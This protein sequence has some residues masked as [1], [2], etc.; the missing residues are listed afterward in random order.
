M[1]ITAGLYKG[2]TLCC[3][4]QDIRPVM[5]KMRES[6][7]SM[8]YSRYA[9][10]SRGL[11]G[12]RFLDLFCGSAVMAVEA[13]SRGACYVEAVERDR[14]K[15]TILEQNLGILEIPWRLHITDVQRYLRQAARP[16]RNIRAEPF[17]II[18]LDPPFAM[19]NKAGLLKELPSTLLHTGSLIMLH[20]PRQEA[21]LLSEQPV[22]GLQR[23]SCKYFG[24]SALCLYSPPVFA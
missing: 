4:K 9:S 15:K 11:D 12:L 19:P 18:Y 17:D 10:G 8:L 1:R 16:E 22:G 14:R 5:A 3:P 24:G 20:L 7:F 2:R 23:E 21:T 6:I 13:A